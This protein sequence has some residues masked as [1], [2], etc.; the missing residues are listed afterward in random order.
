MTSK[1]REIMEHA[2]AWNHPTGRFYRNH[3]VTDP[4]STDGVVIRGLVERGLMEMSVSSDLSGGMPVFRVTEAGKEA[5][6]QP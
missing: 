6:A 5:L 3:F 1:E 2:T 4:E